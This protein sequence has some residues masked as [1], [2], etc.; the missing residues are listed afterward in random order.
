VHQDQ[1]RS[2][3]G[4]EGWRRPCRGVIV[5]GE[6]LA[7]MGE[8]GAREHWGSAG[9]LSPNLI[10][11]EI[12]RRVVIDGGVNLG[13]LLATMATG[14]LRARVTEGGEGG[15]ESLPEDDVVLMM[16][17]VG[18]GRFCTSGSARGRAAAEER[19][20]R[21]CGPAVL[22]EETGIGLLG[23]LRWVMAMLLVH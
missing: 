6:G 10:W 3:A 21:R 8:Q 18:V 14:V 20:R 9:M 22:V 19:A 23:E 2:T 11:I 4:G 15:V 12:G 7:N 5:P 13:F 17:S 1:R 16:P